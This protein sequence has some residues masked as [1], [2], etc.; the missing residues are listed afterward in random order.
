MIIPVKNGGRYLAEAIESVLDQDYRHIELIVVDG[1]STDNTAEIA[2]SYDRVQYILQ[3]DDPGIAAARNIGIEASYG[4]FI[5]FISSDDYWEKEKITVQVQHFINH[6]EIQYSITKVR[7]FL[8]P[9]SEIPRG[10]KPE[11]LKKEVVG[12]MPETL[13]A[14]KS[15]FQHV[16]FFDTNLS[17]LE[18]TDWFSRAKDSG[19]PMRVIDQV[20]LNKRVHQKNISTTP[21]N[22]RVINEEFVKVMKRAIDRKRK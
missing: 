1:R 18:D 21:G 9:G 11:L 20:L 17:L 4:E 8:Q 3:T 16:G 15:L 2:R 7:F 14:R 10:F 12:P 6:P 22:G 13:L 19:V 5:A